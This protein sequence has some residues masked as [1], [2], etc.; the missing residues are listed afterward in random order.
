MVKGLYSGTLGTAPSRGSHM[1]VW[2]SWRGLRVIAA[3]VLA[4]ILAGVAYLFW[5]P[6]HVLIIRN[7][8]NAPL[9]GLIVALGSHRES[10]GRLAPGETVRLEFREDAEGSYR[11]YDSTDGNV[12][13]LGACGYVDWSK[14]RFEHE[15]RISGPNKQMDCRALESSKGS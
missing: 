11:L 8:T 5:P 13:E 15:I 10:V 12:A 9:H 1:S 6:R 2:K 7:E 4:V 3:G 14:S